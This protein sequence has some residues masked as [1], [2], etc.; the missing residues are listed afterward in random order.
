MHY[1]LYRYPVFVFFFSF[2]LCFRV[3]F[4]WPIRRRFFYDVDPR[5]LYA[6]DWQSRK[7]GSRSMQHGSLTGF[8]FK[9]LN[10]LKQVLLFGC[11]CFVFL[12]PVEM[13]M[14]PVISSRTDCSRKLTKTTSVVQ[15]A[16]DSSG[17]QYQHVI[18]PPSCI[19]SFSLYLSLITTA[20]A[21]SIL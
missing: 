19:L 6:F 2:F 15:A 9:K 8:H 4:Y 14:L 5:L 3:L 7:R 13:L 16:V 21:H 10:C 1:H 18:C 17:N 20:E 11:C 12:L